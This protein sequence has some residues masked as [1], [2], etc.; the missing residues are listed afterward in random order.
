[1]SLSTLTRSH[2]HLCPRVSREHPY[3]QQNHLSLHLSNHN[4]VSTNKTTFLDMNQLLNATKI[5]AIATTLSQL[6]TTP[7]DVG[8]R[9][10]R[11]AET[12]MKSTLTA[13]FDIL[14]RKGISAIFEGFPLHLLKRVPTKALTV[15]LFEFG[16]QKISSRQL[17]FSPSISAISH[18]SVA[19]TAGALALLATYPLHLSYYALRKDIPLSR[20][21]ARAS[22]SPRILYAGVFPALLGTA[23]AVFVD[24]TIYRTL[25][26]RVESIG[27]RSDN[28]WDG[29]RLKLWQGTSLIIGAAA[30]SNLMGGFISEPFKALSRKIAVES[31]RG[32]QCETLS[33]IVP[34]MLSNGI[35]EFWRGFPRRSVR[36]A[37][38]A[39]VSKTTVQQLKE[40]NATNRMNETPLFENIPTSVARFSPKRTSPAH[41]IS[42]TKSFRLTRNLPVV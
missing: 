38:S 7:L 1:M 30:T 5:A 33:K 23:P 21:L 40:R 32:S 29:K 26:R 41:L 22:I 39:I 31:I 20:I 16:T 4:T 11:R 34:S 42:T 10:I 25:R 15:A 8:T 17:T 13:T 27:S 35:G 24:Y 3:N 37:V 28:G 18:L 19:T 2:S 12:P 36:Y 6:V 14:R 9:A